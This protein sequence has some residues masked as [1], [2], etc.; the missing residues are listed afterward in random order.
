LPRRRIA[1]STPLISLPDRVQV[2]GRRRYGALALW[3]HAPD[4]G[5]IVD[6]R[7]DGAAINLAR[8]L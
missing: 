1:T 8:D 2:L 3:Q 7:P 4:R 5:R 6:V